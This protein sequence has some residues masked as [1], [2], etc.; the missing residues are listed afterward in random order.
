MTLV[1]CHKKP[2]LSRNS[3]RKGSNTAGVLLDR[4]RTMRAPPDKCHIFVVLLRKYHDQCYRML[5]KS[6]KRLMYTLFQS[7]LLYQESVTFNSDVIVE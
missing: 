4:K 3:G 7:T 1:E 2:D 6:K 5:F